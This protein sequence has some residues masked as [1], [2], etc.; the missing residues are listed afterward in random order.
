MS[1]TH[2]NVQLE[3]QNVSEDYQ[4]VSRVQIFG[5]TGSL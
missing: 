2:K 3:T 1:Q 5:F 4:E